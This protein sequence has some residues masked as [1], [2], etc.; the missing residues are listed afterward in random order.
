LEKRKQRFGT[1]DSA[2]GKK[3]PISN[4]AL[5]EKKQLRAER[6]KLTK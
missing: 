6:F 5:E 4:S 2:H 1:D 3:S